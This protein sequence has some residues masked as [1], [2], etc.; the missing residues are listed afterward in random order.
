M[1][2]TLAIL[3]FL[4]ASS[5][6]VFAQETHI[7]QTK[8]QLY[9]LIE[10]AYKQQLYGRV[11]DLSDQYLLK[12]EQ[13][14]HDFDNTFE[15]QVTLWKHLSA[16][17]LEQEGAA[18][19][20]ENVL[21]QMQP[22]HLIND[23]YFALADYH[24]NNKEYESAI[25]YYNLLDTDLYS[26]ERYAE[27]MFKQGY[28]YFVTKDFVNAEN[29]LVRIRD[30]RDIYYYPS[31]YYYGMVK[32]YD[33]D[34]D[35]A[36]KSFDRVSSSS[37]YRPH[38]PYY[39]AQIYFAQAKYSELI[40][41]G[42]QQIASPDTRKV[43][44]IR[45]LL[46]QAYF[47]QGNYEQ[48]L[49]HLEYYEANT[50]KLSIDEFYQL[51]F[52]QYK[53]GKCQDAI[54]NFKELTNLDTKQGQLVNYYLADCYTKTGDMTSARAAF[55]KVS[56]MPYEVS[57]KEEAL[58]NYGKLSAEL[59]YDR[60]A[61]NTLIKVRPE[62][63]YYQST[64]PIINDILV[65]TDDY[66]NAITILESINN[67]TPELQ[68]TYQSSLYKNGLKLYNENDKQ[69]AKSMFEQS[70]AIN[71]NKATSAS[72]Q[73]W[74]AY[75]LH[76]QGKYTASTESFNKY[77]ELADG[78][79]KLPVA[80]SKYMADYTQAYN[81]LQ[82]ESYGAA[83]KKFKTAIV[84]INQNREQIKDPYIL[85]RVLPDA[86]TRAGDCAFSNNDYSN[87]QLYYEQAI[88][89][90]PVGLVY[91]LYQRALLEGL[92]GKPYDKI[93][94]LEEI[95]DEHPNSAFVDDALMQLGDTYVSLGNT[96]SATNTYTQLILNHYGKS[97]YINAALLK[98]GLISYNRGNLPEALQ[99]YK[100]IFTNNPSSNEA[101]AAMLAI[102]EIYVEDLKDADKYFAYVDSF[103]Q[104]KVSDFAKDSLS[105]VI[106]EKQFNSGDYEAAITDFTKYLDSYKDGS[107]QLSAHFYRAEA[108]S[109]LNRYGAANADY[110]AVIDAGFSN[111]YEDALRKSA[112]I[113]YNHVQD[114]A[115]AFKFYRDLSEHT[116]SP[117]IKYESQLGAL[118]SAFRISND[119]AVLL[120]AREVSDS[121][122]KS[123][124]ED[125]A[126]KYYLA[127]ASYRKG[128]TD[129]ALIAFDQLAK[130]GT[131]NQ[132][133]ESRYMVA[134]ILYDRKELDNAEVAIT[135]A[136]NNN[137]AYPSWVAKGLILLSK[138]YV[139]KGDL[140]NARA[141]VEAVIENFKNDAQVLSQ[142]QT[143]LKAVEQ[144]EAEQSRIKTTNTNRIELDTTNTAGNN[145]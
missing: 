55:K 30:N 17:Y 117:E 44:E 35:A 22:D 53:L 9:E 136:N 115:Q 110:E 19:E 65:N 95:I 86:L 131:N 28:S 113:N 85:E 98:K 91:I 77:Y 125:L 88:D 96:D 133:A 29:N 61:I 48:A 32:Y 126:A 59:G 10:D 145:K 143:Q 45:Q 37:Q 104:Y 141:A 8:H 64:K 57:M 87:A 54:S 18:V 46:G 107:N 111:Y 68:S 121:P 13:L 99:F 137:S 67:R 129:Q 128:M 132:A 83:G 42:E 80:S 5:L 70:L 89:R 134:K 102:E 103:P 109:I 108:L 49:P 43:K 92:Q 127:K 56:Q 71:E 39:I 81:F 106:A 130:S 40:T 90:K 73:Y 140:F 62:S 14:N 58:F 120:F 21:L 144:K 112:I 60:E 97:P 24:Y 16:L 74:L 2:K 84:G 135:N 20:L 26:D 101:Q 47:M 36:I 27:A 41:Y 124:S 12:Q 76:S 4:V 79:G 31:N 66:A 119:D 33:R 63:P 72:S 34:Y 82:N 75:M 69:A 123:Q 6:S 11:I 7:D 139:D 138:I 25:H 142:A 38:I 118:R 15:A 1:R 105:Y 52:T 50:D 122:F 94:T 116:S 114:F 3:L 51:A 78:A 100:R 23:A 93:I